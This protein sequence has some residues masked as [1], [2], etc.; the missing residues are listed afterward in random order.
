ME[1]VSSDNENGDSSDDD[2]DGM[3]RSQTLELWFPPE[4]STFQQAALTMSPTRAI[5]RHPPLPMV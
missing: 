4:H 2:A 3:C 1:M 5:V